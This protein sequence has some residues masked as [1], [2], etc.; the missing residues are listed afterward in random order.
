LNGKPQSRIGRSS[1]QHQG[2]CGVAATSAAT[3]V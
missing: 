3:A 2:E 1:R